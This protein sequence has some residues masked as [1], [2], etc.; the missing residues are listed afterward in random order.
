MRH[1]PQLTEV[2][3]VGAA[4]PTANG[5]A[6]PTGSAGTT[7][8]ADWRVPVPASVMEGQPE[9]DGHGADGGDIGRPAGPGDRHRLPGRNQG[10][11]LQGCLVHGPLGQAGQVGQRLM[12]Y[13]GSIAVGAAQ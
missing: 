5:T 13:P 9:L 4:Q 1:S 6:W 10:S 11:A 8:G 2:L 7:R 3:N 12:P